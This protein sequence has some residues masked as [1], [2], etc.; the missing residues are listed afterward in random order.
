L[1]RFPEI[2]KVRIMKNLHNAMRNMAA[3]IIGPVRASRTVCFASG[4]VF[5]DRGLGFL[6]SGRVFLVRGLVFLVRGLVFLASGL[7]VAAP[8]MSADSGLSRAQYREAVNETNTSYQAH[9]LQCN[10]T[11]RDE[12]T[13]CR[14]DAR[15]ARTEALAAAKARRAFG[16]DKSVDPSKPPNPEMPSG[17]KA[18]KTDI[19]PQ[20]QRDSPP[21]I[22]PPKKK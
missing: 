21:D 22:V 8:A 5:L 10:T 19:A 12:R 18:S 2:S 14:R 13:L 16:P 17:L 7:I 15:A 3:I 6:V 1:N 4:R 11:N 20:L 9:L